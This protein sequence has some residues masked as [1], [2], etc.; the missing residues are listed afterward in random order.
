MNR[1]VNQVKE[2]FA[3]LEINAEIK[4]N[5]KTLSING[6]NFRIPKRTEG[7]YGKGVDFDSKVIKHI[8]TLFPENM[9]TELKEKYHQL[10]QKLSY[11]DIH[12]DFSHLNY[13]CFVARDIR[14]SIDN[15]KKLLEFVSNYPEFYTIID[16]YSACRSLV[17]HGWDWITE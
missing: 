4:F 3:T 2:W 17:E 13:G 15:A 10:V 7:V 1:T 5:G 14:S 12:I 9:E 11:Q 8:R 6:T 16:Q